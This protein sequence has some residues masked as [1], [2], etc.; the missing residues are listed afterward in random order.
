MLSVRSRT[1]RLGTTGAMKLS[2]KTTPDTRVG[3]GYT[4]RLLIG[5]DPHPHS[6][7][8]QPLKLAGFHDR[9]AGQPKKAALSHKSR[10]RGFRGERGGTLIKL[11]KV[12]HIIFISV[13]GGETRSG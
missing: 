5:C 4:S 7:R 13:Y 10:K 2:T 6:E 8:V 11:G 12:Y 1:S 3:G 9:R